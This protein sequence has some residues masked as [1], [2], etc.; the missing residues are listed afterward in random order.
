MI[1]TEFLEVYPREMDQARI[2]NGVDI[3]EVRGA[4]RYSYG[5]GLVAHAAL[6]DEREQIAGLMPPLR[7]Y[8][9]SVPYGRVEAALLDTPGGWAHRSEITF[10]QLNDHMRDLWTPLMAGGW[11]KGLDRLRTIGIAMNSLAVEGLGYYLVREQY[12]RRHGSEGLYEPKMEAFLSRFTGALQELDVAIVVLD[13]IRRHPNLTVVPAPIQFERSSSGAN[14]DLLVIDA[15]EGRVVGVQTKTTT[16]R[17]SIERYDASR[18]VV[19]D[20][21]IDLGNVRVVRTQKGRS[22]TQPKPWP[23]IVAAS[24]VHAI[25]LHGAHQHVPPRYAR[26]IVGHKMQARQAVGTLRVDHRNLSA[27]IS[28]RILGKL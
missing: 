3:P 21:T 10:H 20:G 22:T 5:Y 8:E 6:R 4:Q 26:E 13:V 14:A 9:D 17:R 18:V 1:A 23:G 11:P 12:V 25:Q 15:Q 7:A 27:M 2:H 19:V 16:S 28:E 24:R